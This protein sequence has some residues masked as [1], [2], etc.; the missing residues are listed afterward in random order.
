MISFILLRDH[1]DWAQLNAHSSRSHAILCVK[2]TQ[3]TEDTIRVSRA[4]CIDLAGSE[5]N[6]RT[7]NNKERLVESSA[8]NK[9]LFVL[10]QCVDAINKKQTRIPY[11]ESKMTRILSLGQNSGLTVMVLNLAPT[12][13]YHLD[14][15]AS[16]NFASRTKKIEVSEVENDPIY[17]AMA[18]P[19]AAVS[20]IGGA[21]I[22]RQPLR[23]LTAAHNAN[24]Q[25]VDKKKQGQKPN[26]AFSVFSDSRKPGIRGSNVP[27]QNQGVR[28]LETHKRA[29][30]FS[31][32]AS[33]P[34]KTYRSADSTS[35][36]RPFDGVMSKESIEAMISQRIDEKLAERALQDAAV[37]APA[38]SAELQRR[39]DDLEQRVE[40]RDDDKS[41]PGLQFLLMGKQHLTRGEEVSALRMFQLALPYFPGNS[42]LEA[43]IA[44]LEES[45]RSRRGMESGSTQAASTHTSS[46]MAPLSTKPKR[47]V[48]EDEADDDEF[49]PAD[50]SDHDESYASDSSFKFK[51]PVR[52]TKATTKKLPIF[53]DQD[54]APCTAGSE[55][56]T[57]RTSRLLKI[58]N[59]KDVA[60]IKA[61]KGVGSKKADAIVS[62]LVDMDDEEIQD[63]QM[64]AM[65]KGVGERSVETMRLG[66]TVTF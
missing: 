56:Q 28:R 30:E 44:K 4:S 18:K 43:K 20:S 48:H 52:K 26:K 27:A 19:L 53:R 17:R 60:Q 6:R 54:V 15:L 65:L 62:C 49:E 63:L 12:R 14:T 59:T 39:L 3:T 13:A 34:T 58:I 25:E 2:I 11:R 23:P 66:L 16:L 45:I 8:I 57:P 42:R 7:E 61:L 21:N 1:T 5:D 22:T 10:A 38:L 31:A 9:S 55:E 47:I 32:P 40:A 41:G 35:R 37:A 51:K 36:A 64:L 29:A 33:R 46:R 50:A 24:L